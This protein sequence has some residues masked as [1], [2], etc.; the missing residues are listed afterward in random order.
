MCILSL[1]LKKSMKKY[2]YYI[3]IIVPIQAKKEIPQIY[4]F[5]KLVLL[6]WQKNWLTT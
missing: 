6:S 3:N 2:N 5:K 4:Y 1:N